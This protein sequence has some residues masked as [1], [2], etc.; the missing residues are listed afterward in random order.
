MVTSLKYQALQNARTVPDAEV[1]RDQGSLWQGVGYSLVG[2]GAAG[3]IAGALILAAG[4]PKQA[5]PIVTL[6]PGGASI[7]LV[8]VL[9]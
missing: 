3:L 1:Y 9:P 8:G 7:G 5:T 6:V 2:V 4:A